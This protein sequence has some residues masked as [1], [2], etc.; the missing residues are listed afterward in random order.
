MNKPAI[1]F[2]PAR[3]SVVT[4][5]K[6]LTTTFQFT[7][8]FAS[9]P[10]TA[11]AIQAPPIVSETPTMIPRIAHH[12]TTGASFGRRYIIDFAA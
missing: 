12:R 4:P 7:I 3:A 6:F 1:L 11:S 8:G 9:L 10:A 2:Q 5:S